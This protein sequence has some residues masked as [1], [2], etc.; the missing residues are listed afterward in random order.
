MPRHYFRSFPNLGTIGTTRIITITT[1]AAQLVTLTSG[2]QAMTVVN[3]GPSTVYWGDSS[4]LASSGVALTINN[5]VTWTD[6]DDAWSTYFRASSVA[7]VIG[8]NEYRG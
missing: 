7:T 5:N 3:I 1:A 2:Y 8:V 4:I 6:L